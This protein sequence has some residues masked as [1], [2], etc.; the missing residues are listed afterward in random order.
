M[1][2]PI[3]LDKSR[4]II[5]RNL[6]MIGKHHIECVVEMSMIKSKFYIVALD[7]YANRYHV[8]ELWMQQ[9]QKLVKACD[10]DLEKLMKMLDFKLGKLYI[11]H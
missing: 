2:G 5:W 8:I 10:Q 4:K 3:L 7:L 6:C 1:S 9:A 11:K